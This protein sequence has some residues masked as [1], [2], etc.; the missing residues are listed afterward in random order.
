MDNMTQHRLKQE[1]VEISK[2]MPDMNDD[3]TW[4]GYISDRQF[5]ITS[6]I[7]VVSPNCNQ[8]FSVGNSIELN[9]TVG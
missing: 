5:E 6:F 4:R 7:G 9:E 1:D 8:V 2:R 3:R